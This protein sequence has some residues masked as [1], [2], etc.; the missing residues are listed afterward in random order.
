[1]LSLS[2]AEADTYN[3]RMTIQVV[4][5][6]N[7]TSTKTREDKTA[8]QSL[9]AR[10]AAYAEVEKA[11][12][13]YVIKLCRLTVVPYLT[14]TYL[15]GELTPSAEATEVGPMCIPEMPKG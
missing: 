12:S 11:C 6:I 15:R 9:E 3:I 14:L 5:V 7:L 4:C 8:E 13:W 2:F 10:K 1:M